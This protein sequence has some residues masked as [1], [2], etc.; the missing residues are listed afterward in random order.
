MKISLWITILVLGFFSTSWAAPQ[1]LEAKIFRIAHSQGPSQKID[2]DIRLPKNCGQ[3]IDLKTKEVQIKHKLHG[4]EIWL[5][6]NIEKGPF[7]GVSY[8]RQP[9]IA[10]KFLKQAKP[11][12]DFDIDF[13]YPWPAD[14]SEFELP[15][16]EYTLHIDLTYRGT[17]VIDQ[18]SMSY[19]PHEGIWNPEYG[20][21]VHSL[22]N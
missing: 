10:M 2:L 6:T 21:V 15:A 8:C 9:Q 17:L 7:I 11:L 19:I 13:T 12:T 22:K 1:P 4:G 18:D 5:Q 3:K 16:G 20:F 14:K